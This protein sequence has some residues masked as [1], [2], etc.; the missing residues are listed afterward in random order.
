MKAAM[1][2]TETNRVKL[3][4]TLDAR[5]FEQGV[6][7]AYKSTVKRY[8]V[9]G[10]RRG[11]APRFVIENHYGAG[12][13]YQDAFENLFPDAY[14][15]AVEE[16]GIYPVNQ[17]EIDIET[18][19]KEEGLVIV[20]DVTVKPEVTLG[21]YKGLKVDRKI[22][23][24]TD[25]DI[26]HE[27][28]HEREK[29]ARFYEVDDRPAQEGDEVTIDYKGF[30]NGEA[31]EGGSDEEAKLVLGSGRFI[32]GFE[33]RIAGMNVGERKAIDVTFP[34]DYH[35]EDLAGKAVVFEVLLHSIMTRELPELDDEFAK[36][37]SEFDTLAEYRDSVRKKLEEDSLES[38]NRRWENELVRLASDN[39]E[40]EVPAVMVEKQID[41]LFRDM[42]YRMMWQG[43]RLEQYFEMTGTTP[44]EMR[45]ELWERA[46]EDVR[47]QLT[48]EAI[49]KA[50]NIEMRD[51]DWEEAYRDEA[52]KK[53]M[54]V[55]EYMEEK[56]SPR[57]KERKE[58]DILTQKTLALL[59]ESAEH[60]DVYVDDDKDDEE[61]A[62]EAEE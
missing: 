21:E 49:R 55:E 23:K 6:Q 57:E 42:E 18:I 31:F 35:A 60:A 59:K 62:E 14:D 22:Q 27:I 40:I 52:A 8:N 30:L 9:P 45:E 29:G 19:G 11:K 16:T 43:L 5:E 46:E 38:A 47:M 34:E 36:D 10:F 37:V 50:E 25:A 61:S 32:P 20:C 7:K 15:K 12:V 58:G 39:A 26:D 17:P 1:E 3:T 48:L 54:T 2:T 4:I 51:S 13:F 53:D 41:Y 24:V 28:E 33:E 44:E 56:V